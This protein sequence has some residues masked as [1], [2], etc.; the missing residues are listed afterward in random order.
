MQHNTLNKATICLYIGPMFSGKTDR[1][2]RELRVHTHINS[3]LVILFK[4]SKD[5]REEGSTVLSRS[6]ASGEASAMIS[7]GREAWANVKDSIT[8]SP[9]K[10]IVVI[11]VD[12]G[13]FID[14]LDWF[15]KKVLTTK[16]R[17]RVTF[18][19]H[20]A[21]L[22]STFKAEMWERVVK[23]IPYCHKVRKSCA[24]C[25]ICQTLPAQLT[26]KISGSAEQLEEI[27]SDQYKAVCLGCYEI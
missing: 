22:D 21:A 11:G 2:L 17:A 8:G 15:V 3:A 24:V 18:K 9:N 16:L 10:S 6:G 19:V 13:Q 25:S 4:Y 5:D 14:D 7:T 26:K 23:L 20:I 1:M 27:G 12:E